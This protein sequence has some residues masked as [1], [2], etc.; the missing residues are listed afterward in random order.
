MPL[1]TAGNEDVWVIVPTFNEAPVVRGVLDGLRRYFPKVVAVDDGSGD[2]SSAEIRAAG[3]RLV[4]HPV[5]LGAGAAIQ[6]GLDFAMLDPDA[7]LFVTFDADGQHDPAD[8]AAMVERIRDSDLHVL[9]GSR[10]LGGAHGIKASR[11]ALLAAARLFERTT[12]SVR[13][14]DA[15]NGLR[16]FSREFARQL[17]LSFAD[18]AHASEFLERIASSGLAYAEHP[19]AISYTEY[20]RAKGQRNINS[21]NIAVDVWMHHLLYGRASR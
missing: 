20:S 10:F 1:P 17:N 9:I 3:V 5:N 14:T 18:F 7:R 8:A 2:D 15:H 13:L 4:R 16:V 12:T 11:R 19:V 6:T 21:V